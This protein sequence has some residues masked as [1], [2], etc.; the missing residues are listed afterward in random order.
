MAGKWIEVLRDEYGYGRTYCEKH[1]TTIALTNCLECQYLRNWG[2]RF[3]KAT[4]YVNE[5]VS[6]AGCEKIQCVAAESNKKC[7]WALFSGDM[8]WHFCKNVGKKNKK[9][10]EC[11][12]WYTEDPD[13]TR[14]YYRNE[15][16]K[17]VYIGT[18]EPEC[19]G[20]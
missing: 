20:S 2:P 5:I 18:E 7:N 13:Y 11:H 17:F 19:E 14:H 10:H 4:P 6:F 8:S 1:K 15:H 3:D 9:N 16:G 12:L